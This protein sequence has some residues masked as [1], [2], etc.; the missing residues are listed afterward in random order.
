MLNRFLDAFSLQLPRRCLV[1][2]AIVLLTIADSHAA[3]SDGAPF[4]RK[5]IA[6]VLEEFC[7]RC[8]AGET[9]KGG[10]AFD[11]AEAALLKNRELWL[12]SLKMLRAGM[13]P[14]QGKPRPTAEQIAQVE[15]WI[16]RS[17][18]GIDPKNPDPGRVTVRRLNRVEYRNTIRDLM[19]VDFNTDADFPPTI[20]ATASTTSATY[21][22]SRR[23]CWRSTSRRLG[24]SSRRRCRLSRGWSPRSAYR[25]GSSNR[26]RITR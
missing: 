22:P 5:N 10:I 8:H 13:M 6:P 24:P 3:D 19:G 20:P 21:S 7:G 2:I 14:P 12:K 9:G 18:F 11:Q 25:A 23:S 4:Y 26:Q 15:E 1:A 17:A 16:K